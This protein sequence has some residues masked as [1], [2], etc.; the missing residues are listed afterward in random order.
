MPGLPDVF[1]RWLAAKRRDLVKVAAAGDQFAQQS[2]L[3]LEFGIAVLG[4]MFE[5]KVGKELCGAAV[6][7]ESLSQG[8]SNDFDTANARN[9]GA[10]ERV[11]GGVGR[12]LNVRED[13]NGRRDGQSGSAERGRAAK[14]S[15]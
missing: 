6:S 12:S 1:N 8:I 5:E 13:A 11:H 7:Q 15:S 9:E 10:E 14:G 3:H 4:P 2:R